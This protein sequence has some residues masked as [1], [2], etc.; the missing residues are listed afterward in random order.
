MDTLLYDIDIRTF[1]VE[2]E[3]CD[4]DRS[5][6]VLPDGFEWNKEEGIYNTDA[7]C[8]KT[9]GGEINTPPM[10]FNEASLAQI[11]FVYDQLKEAGGQLKWSIDTHVHVY[12]GDLSLE[13]VKRLIQFQYLTYPYFKQYSKLGP[14]DEIAL[15]GKPLITEAKYKALIAAENIGEIR[16]LLSNQSQKGYIRYAI[17]VASI[18]VR[19][20]VE[21]RC[22]NASDKF[23]EVRNCID[24]TLKM[25][26]YAINHTAEDFMAISSYEE[27]V[28]IMDLPE[29]TP[30]LLIPLL[31]QGNP[32]HAK[33]AFLASP[34]GFNTKMC[35]ALKDALTAHN[36]KKVAVVNGSF[37]DYELNLYK[38]YGITIYNED[39]YKHLLWELATQDKKIVYSGE[40]EWLQKFN[41]KEAVRQVAVALYVYKIMKVVPATNDFKAQLLDAYKQKA[42]DSIT[43]IEP[44]AKRLIEMLSKAEYH[45]GNLEDALPNEEMLFFSFGKKYKH[46]R[47]AFRTITSYSDYE[48]ELE[49][50]RIQ[51]NGLVER[52]P[53]TSTFLMFSASPYFD[54]LHK[55][56]YLRNAGLYRESCGIFLYSN[57][58]HKSSKATSSY[59][60]QLGEV[61][62]NVPPDDLRIEDAKKLKIFRVPSGQ[63]FQLQKH[64]IHKVDK[65]SQGIFSFVFMYDDYCLGGVS[66]DFPRGAEFDLWQLSDFCTNNNV[67]RLSKLI[68]LLILSKPLQRMLSRQIGRKILSV[69]SYAYTDAPVSMKYRGVYK[70]NSGLCQPHRLAYVG[71]LGSYVTIED[72]VKKYLTYIQN[73]RR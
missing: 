12:G 1:G 52:I 19:K 9:H 42:E 39:G 34:L 6:V 24:G 64:F 28:K 51:Y 13:Q 15:H 68:L 50:K 4:F 37:F 35:A 40:L 69:I 58:E 44:S 33:D 53:E 47:R 63:F 11:K 71:E 49:G 45:F 54:N 2:I 10:I 21:F 55:I 16:K 60:K 29:P 25:F 3:M 73:A 62:I 26:Y 48:T 17:N 59:S 18:F 41:S 38:D 65:L 56:A 30:P 27:F 70:K 61:S 20:T 23:E 36:C 57:K 14:W 46:T 66:F 5:K 72:C 31:Y 22:F 67:P 32:Y 8:C 43:K 7:V